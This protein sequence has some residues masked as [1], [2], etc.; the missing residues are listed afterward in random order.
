MR[1]ALGLI[2]GQTSRRQSRRVLTTDR[3][4]LTARRTVNHGVT[5][6]QH[7]PS[8]EY[9]LCDVL[10]IFQRGPGARRKKRGPKGRRPKFE[11]RDRWWSSYAHDTLIRNRR[12]ELIPENRYRF[13]THLTCIMQIMQ[14]LCFFLFLFKGSSKCGFSTLLPCSGF[15]ILLFV[16]IMYFYLNK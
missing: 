3:R 11:R 1:P 15:I 16:C 12:Q 8:T 6:S 7:C 14:I 2:T 10:G 4:P 9:R 13:L 5:L